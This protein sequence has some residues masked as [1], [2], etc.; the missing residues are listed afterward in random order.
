[1]LQ[2]LFLNLLPQTVVPTDCESWRFRAHCSEIRGNLVEAVHGDLVAEEAA[3]VGGERPQQDGH[4]ALGE[5]ADALLAHDLAE[6]VAHAVVR[7]LGRCKVQRK[8]ALLRK[9]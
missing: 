6:D 3:G 1:M 8:R 2:N 5:A 9:P 7:A 4:G